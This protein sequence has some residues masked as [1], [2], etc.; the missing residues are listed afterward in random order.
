MAFAKSTHVGRETTI[1]RVRWD[2]KDKTIPSPNVEFYDK[3][4][5]T[6]SVLLQPGERGGIDVTGK[7]TNVAVFSYQGYND[8]ERGTGEANAWRAMVVLDNGEPADSG[9]V[10]DLISD[11]GV[12]NPH[13]LQLLNQIAAHLENGGKDT[14]IKIGLYRKEKDGKSYPASSVRL[15][16]GTD[17]HGNALFEDY[18]N[19]VKTDLPPRGTPVLDANGNEVKANGQTVYSYDV[20]TEW[21]NELMPKIMAHFP[22]KGQNEAEASG[23]ENINNQM[24]PEAHDDESVSVGEAVDAAIPEQ[25]PAATRPRFGTKAG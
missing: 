9:L 13:T 2:I 21:L 12:P 4:T 6:A 1:G 22:R 3:E 14:P 10:L 11:T 7:I 24:A 16:S 20:V 15:P 8:R 23:T 19:T 17:E 5:K 18:K 25:T